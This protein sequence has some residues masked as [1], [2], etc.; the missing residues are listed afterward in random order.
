MHELGIVFYIIRDA[1]AAAVENGAGSISKVVLNVGEVSTVVPHLLEDCWKW[2]V[3]REEMTRG[4]TLQ[5]NTV[6][7]ITRCQ[8]CG[9]RYPTVAHGKICPHCGSPDTFLVQGN[10]VELQEIEVKE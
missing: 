4:C 3:E 8:G 1:K 9:R 10:E 5:I 2:A 6:P 7:A